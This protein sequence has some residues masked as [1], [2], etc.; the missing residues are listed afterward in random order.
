MKPGTP[1]KAELMRALES[2]REIRDGLIRTLEGVAKHIGLDDWAAIA[3]DPSVVIGWPAAAV[4]A[5]VRIEREACAQFVESFDVKVV[6]PLGRSH[7]VGAR[8]LIPLAAAI[9]ARGDK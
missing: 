8:P 2:A 7:S 6:D 9:R 5:A 1:T 4:K 3:E